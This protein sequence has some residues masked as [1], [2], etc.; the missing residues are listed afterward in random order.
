MS[1]TLGVFLCALAMLVSGCTVAH[2][3]YIRNLSESDVQLTFVFDQDAAPSLRDSMFVPSSPTAHLVNNST[4]TF[5]TDSIIAKKNGMTTLR[6]VL[7]YGA[8]IMIDKNTSRK[9]GYNDPSQIEVAIPTKNVKYRLVNSAPAAGQKQLKSKGACGR[10]H[11][12][13]IY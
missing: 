11:W 3:T 8:M 9:V 6:L 2:F 10:I 7:P 1:K 13:D 5:M 4:Y 12:H